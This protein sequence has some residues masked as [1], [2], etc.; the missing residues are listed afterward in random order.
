MKKKFY[1]SILLLLT[2]N[3]YRQQ[4]STIKFG[5]KFGAAFAKNKLEFTNNSVP[6]NLKTKIGLMAGCYVDFLVNEKML[7]QP[8]LLYVRKGAKEQTGY[9]Y[10]PS[11][12]YNYLE[13]PLNILYRSPAKNGRYFFGGGLSPAFRFTNHLYGN[14]LKS[15]DLGANVLAGYQFPMGFSINL[16]YTYGMLNVSKFK[17]SISKIQNRYFSLPVGYE[18]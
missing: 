15:F 10:S 6:Y 18:F 12:I 7:F 17:E 11:L 4:A 2:M 14:E 5:I 9:T 16:G 1:C 8:A 3:A 13:I